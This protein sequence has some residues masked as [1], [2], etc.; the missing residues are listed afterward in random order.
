GVEGAPRPP[1]QSASAGSRR[2]RVAPSPHCLPG[3]PSAPRKRG[4]PQ[5]SGACAAA[6]P[7]ETRSAIVRHALQGTHPPCSACVSVLLLLRRQ[8]CGC[9]RACRAPLTDLRATVSSAAEKTSG[10]K[11][12]LARIT[13][14]RRKCASRKNPIT[15]Q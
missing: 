9:A 13:A 10:L 7:N 2:C 12:A 15:G 4:A 3:L 6:L 14:A 8:G 5:I 1:G 11:N